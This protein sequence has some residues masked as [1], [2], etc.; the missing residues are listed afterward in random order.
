MPDAVLTSST[1]AK[2]LLEGEFGVPADTVVTLP[3]CADPVAFDPARFPEDRTEHPL[4]TALGI[5]P[6]HTV[7]GYLG[8]LTDYQGITPHH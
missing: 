5:P 7:V 4:R 8:L 2:R 3:D 1:R 6:E